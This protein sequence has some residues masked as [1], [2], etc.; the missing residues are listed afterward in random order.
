[1]VLHLQKKG[2]QAA[3]AGF[4][5]IGVLGTVGDSRV[6]TYSSQTLAGSPLCAV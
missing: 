5:E 2:G 3:L 1:M 4:G 6:K